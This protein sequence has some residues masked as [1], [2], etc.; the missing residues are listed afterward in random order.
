VRGDKDVLNL[1]AR[2]GIGVG[3]AFPAP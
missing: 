3:L 2:A 1:G